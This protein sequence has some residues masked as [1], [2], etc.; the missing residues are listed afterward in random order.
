M[1]LALLL[2]AAPADVAALQPIEP[3]DAIAL[4]KRVCAD[5]FPD[6]T[7]F[8][9][10]VAAEPGPFRKLV[11]TPAEAMQP[12]ERYD[13][14]RAQIGYS[15]GIGLPLDLPAPQC[16]VGARLA[17]APDHPAIAAAAA[18]ALGLPV[19]KT[20][21]KG[22]LETQWDAAT[23]AGRFRYFFVTETTAAG[24]YEFRLTLLNLRGR[25]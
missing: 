17:T 6:P 5:P 13:G 10:A 24:T 1:I 2:S 23:P 3:G 7:R 11:K 18:A 12:G 16:T 4:F 9:A 22:R 8:A 15:D 20:R 19:G 14:D 21:G 25:K